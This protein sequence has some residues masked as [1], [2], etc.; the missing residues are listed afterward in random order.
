MDKT[1][2]PLTEDCTC[3]GDV[4]GMRQVFSVL[5]CAFVQV[6]I[7]RVYQCVGCQRWVPWCYGGSPEIE[8]C[9]DC[10]TELPT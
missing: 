4:C 7:G 2:L 8:F 1:K 10:C 3:Q 6:P 9:D 5:E